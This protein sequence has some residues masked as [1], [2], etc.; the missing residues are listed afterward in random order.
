MAILKIMAKRFATY[1]GVPIPPFKEEKLGA[2]SIAIRFVITGKIPSKKNNQQS[3][4]VRK[5]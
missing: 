4:A 1:F 2:G 3:V 5:Y